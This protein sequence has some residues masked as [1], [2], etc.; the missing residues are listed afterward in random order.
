MLLF[1]RE[2]VNNP[3]F[4]IV[5]ERV[6]NLK[7]TEGGQNAVCAVMEKY[8][9]QAREAG[10]A[11]GRAEGRMEGTLNALSGLVRD[12]VISIA[13]AARRANMSLADFSAKTGL[14]LPN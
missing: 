9:K 2:I 4:P 6:S 5:S 1:S 14:P 3:R 12:G 13:E 7:T 10:L 11:E 8:E